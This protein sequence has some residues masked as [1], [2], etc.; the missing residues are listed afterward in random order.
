LNKDDIPEAAH[1]LRRNAEHFF[2]DIC[3][4]LGAP[5]RYKGIYQWKLGDYAPA[6]I[7]AFKKY[8]KKA[9]NN[10]QAIGD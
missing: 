5:V 3:D 7:S 6:A 4:S 10:A 1:R 8:L 2:D 9:K